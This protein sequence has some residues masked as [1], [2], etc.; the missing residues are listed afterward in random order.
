M[1]HPEKIEKYDGT[2]TQLAEDLGNLRYDALADFL[3][4]L[5]QKIQA[6]GKKD[7]ARGRTQL[8]GSLFNCAQVL[9]EGA[10]SIDKAWKISEPYMQI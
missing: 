5:S 1:K 9:S 6:D 10:K 4:D 7:E 2:L 8:A 3:R